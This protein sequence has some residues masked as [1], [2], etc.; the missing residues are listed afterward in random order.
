MPSASAAARL[1]PSAS[2]A[3]ASSA[4]CWRW[5]PRGWASTSPSWS[6]RPTA[7][8]RAVAAHAIVGAYDDPAA[9]AGAGRLAPGGRPTS[10]RTCRP[11]RSLHLPALGVEVAPGAEALAVAQDRV[12][13]KTLPQRRRRRRPSPS[14]S[15]DAPRR[16]WP[17]SPSSARPL[18]MKTRREGYDGKGQALG[19]ARRPTRRRLRGAGRRAGDPGGARPPSCASCRSSPPAAATA[20]PAIYPLAENHHENG[21]LRRSLAPAK[22]EPG[23]PCAGRADRRPRADRA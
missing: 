6:A 20:Q 7:P 19:R 9:L 4:A 11:P 3:A 5:P 10:S 14:P 8:P 16:P 18:L 2:W 23:P 13:E 17:R 1:A 22:V 21:I 15:A 12:A